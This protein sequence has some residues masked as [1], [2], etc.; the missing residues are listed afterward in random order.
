LSLS[1]ARLTSGAL[2]IGASLDAPG[3]LAIGDTSTLTVAGATV[4]GGAGDAAFELK[5]GSTSSF[6][7]P[8]FPSQGAATHSGVV[9][10]QGPTSDATATIH[11]IW[12]TGDLVVGDA[13]RAT[14]DV[15]ATEIHLPNG[16]YASS[17][18]RLSSG[19]ASIAAQPG[20][21]GTVRV[22]GLAFPG[23]VSNWTIASSLSVGGTSAAAG[24]V[25]ELIIGGANTVSVGG[26]LKLWPGATLTRG[27]SSQFAITGAASLGGALEYTLN[28]FTNPQ[29]G[30]EYPVLSAAG[31]VTGAFAASVLP[32]LAGGLRWVLDYRPTSVALVVA[33][34]LSADFNDD[35]DVDAADLAKWRGDFATNAQSDADGDGDSDGA[36]FIAWQG[37]IGSGTATSAAVSVAE[38]GTAA[39]AAWLLAVGCYA[40]HRRLF[41]A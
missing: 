13:G 8:S 30:N 9:M 36:D 23:A 41:A 5:A 37:Q 40:G 27:E 19:V 6:I 1:N 39:L 29:L 22:T 35:G 7:G 16:L 25:G 26:G 34:P 28:Q 33:S 17:A 32:P 4:L 31:G 10:A 20:S 12:N 11:G 14:L 2:S 3:R 18:G 24:G 15:L 21:A 38:P